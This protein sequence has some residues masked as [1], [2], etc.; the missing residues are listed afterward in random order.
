MRP[1]PA[2]TVWPPA[3]AGCGAGEG[4]RPVEQVLLWGFALL[5][6]FPLFVLL[7]HFDTNTLTSWRWTMTGAVLPPLFL[8]FTGA[9]L[10]AF[11][12][13]RRLAVENISGW[14]LPLLTAA[15]VWPFFS[16]PES[17][18]DSGRYFL[19]ARYLESYG[20]G[21]F[22]AQWGRQVWAWSDMPLSAFFYGTLFR[23]GGESRLLCQVANTLLFGMTV[24]LTR[25]TGA[26][27]WDRKTGTYGALLLLGMPFLLVL[28]PQ[29]LNDTHVI[30]CVML[31]LYSSLRVLAGGGRGWQLLTG[32]ALV[33]T[34]FAKYST[35]PMLAV[36]G[37]LFQVLPPMAEQPFPNPTTPPKQENSG[38]PRQLAAF[39]FLQK[40][41]RSRLRLAWLAGV[42]ASLLLLYPLREVI[43][44][45][46]VLLATYQA[47]GLA[48]W[49]EGY[50]STFFFQANPWVALLAVWG[51]LIALWQGDRRFMAVAWFP[52]LAVALGMARSRYL[53]PFFPL[54]A[55]A[56][57]CGLRHIGHP[58]LKRCIVAGVLVWGVV[59]AHGGYAPFLAATSMANLLDAG[60]YLNTLEGPAVRVLALPQSRSLGDTAAVLPVL[61]LYTAKKLY[62][63]G[64]RNPAPH[65]LGYQTS[66]QFSREMPL[67][68]E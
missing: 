30:F 11:V 39:A 59:V 17:L 9:V 54:L 16:L 50:F 12:L 34:V 28:V 65:G 38:W 35:W 29:L 10:T 7:R 57:A 19:Q 44:R 58:W 3:P 47:A 40:T 61:D 14:L 2:E 22:L 8:I 32:V 25:Q 66:L 1:L 64:H 45:Q 4:I 51:A 13:C 63:A 42:L 55:L 53:L 15:M 41:P 56:A 49:R 43:V 36:M 23:V 33:L 52:L 46:L 48:H 37:V 68:S 18:L 27:L 24:Y 67:T 5:V 6:S 26:L 31:L 60:R 20:P 62:L 21:R